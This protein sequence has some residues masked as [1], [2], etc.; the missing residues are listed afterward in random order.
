MRQSAQLL[1]VAELDSTE[2][3]FVTEID[4]RGLAVQQG[5]EGRKLLVLFLL[6]ALFLFLVVFLDLAEANRIAAGGGRI[7]VGV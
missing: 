1:V 4:I 3:A 7:Q 6:L 5:G 2:E